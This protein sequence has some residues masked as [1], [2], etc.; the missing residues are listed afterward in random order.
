MF[1]TIEELIDRQTQRTAVMREPL[2]ETGILRTKALLYAIHHLVK[3]PIVASS[4]K[5]LYIDG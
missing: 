2:E 3:G 4:Y 5:L 1:F